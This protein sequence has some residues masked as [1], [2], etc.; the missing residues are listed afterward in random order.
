MEACDSQNFG[1]S[2]TTSAGPEWLTELNRF[3]DA[4]LV[5][6][7]TEVE[8]AYRRL[9]AALQPLVDES[10]CILIGIMMGGLIPLARLAGM[11]EGDFKMDYCQ[12]SRYRG[13][14]RGG[15]PE[16]LRAPSLELKGQ[17]VL[18]I[19]DIFD[20]GVTLEFAVDAC[21]EQGA[22]RVFTAVLVHKRHE[23]NAGR[24]PPDFSGLDVADHYVFGC[25]MDYQHRWRHLPDIYALKQ[26]T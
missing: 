15:K 4:T 12:V 5:A 21:R 19:D 18:L 24:A 6:S 1:G 17:T 2:R 25:G 13:G 14:V 8:H 7:E 11:L 10:S 3:P 23:R 9:A 16:W 26:D 20:E 22:A